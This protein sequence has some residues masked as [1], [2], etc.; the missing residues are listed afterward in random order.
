[1][2]RSQMPKLRLAASNCLHQNARKGC[3]NATPCL[4]SH[5]RSLSSRNN[6]NQCVISKSELRAC[7]RLFQRSGLTDSSGSKFNRFWVLSSSHL[8]TI[9]ACYFHSSQ[10]QNLPKIT[11]PDDKP[12]E[13]MF[14][15]LAPRT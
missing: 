12:E 2:L 7:Y 4:S 5:C 3:S 8:P 13:G 1:M 14:T 6:L 11:P 10:N 15:M 9:S